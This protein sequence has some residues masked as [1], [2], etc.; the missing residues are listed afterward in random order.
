[1]S[2]SRIPAE[3]THSRGCARPKPGKTIFQAASRGHRTYSPPVKEG[4][5][6]LVPRVAS[7]LLAGLLA[8]GL[9]ACS[10]LRA[11][12][13]ARVLGDIT[14]GAGPSRLKRVTPT[15]LRSVQ[16]FAVGGRERVGDLY[17][18]GHLPGQGATAKLVLIPGA[19]RTGR[20]DPR[21]IALAETL[22]RARFAVLVPEIEGLRDL[23]VSAEQALDVADAVRF[24]ARRGEAARCVGI[25]AISFAAGP[26]ILAA[27]REDT[28]D[29][30]CFIVIVGGYYEMQAAVTFFT[31]GSYRESA[32]GTWRHRVPNAYGKWVFVRNNAGRLSDPGDRV[33][34]AAMAE[35]KMKDLDAE[36]GDLAATL[37]P[38]GRAVHALIV[39]RDPGRVPDLI[40]ALPQGVRRDMAALDLKARDLSKLAA[41]LLL[42]HGRDDPIIPYTQSQS[43]AAALPA[44]RAKLYLVGSLSHVDLGPGDAIDG[45]T[46]WRAVYGLLQERDAAA[47][48]SR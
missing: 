38:E 33:R 46:L 12:E 15:P 34:L 3:G 36:I 40:A 18:P 2:R 21:L 17:L 37:G 7:R 44:D 23:R 42:I 48:L 20:R 28:R 16:S 5:G 30:V 25:V 45:L 35:R 1:M 31:T 14:A 19:S 32:T 29:R 27:L 10:P 22:A 13:A 26:A 8:I 11:I 39:N 47:R 43:L 4:N 24:L 9:G 6:V 41:R